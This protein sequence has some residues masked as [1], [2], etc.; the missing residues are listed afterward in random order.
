MTSEEKLIAFR[1]IYEAEL[2]NFPGNDSEQAGRWFRFISGVPEEKYEALMIAVSESW[3]SR[4]GKPRLREFRTVW[5]RMQFQTSPDRP[6]EAMCAAC[7]DHG[8]IVIPVHDVRQDGKHLRYVFGADD[9]GVLTEIACPCR[10][11]RGR[12]KQLVLGLSDNLCNEAW[13]FYRDLMIAAGHKQIEAPMSK[14]EYLRTQPEHRC[15]SPNGMKWRMVFDSRKELREALSSAETQ[16]KEPVPDPVV[17]EPTPEPWQ[18]RE[19]ELVG[20]QDTSFAF[21]KSIGADVEQVAPVLPGGYGDD[22]LPF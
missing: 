10:C 4:Q 7:Y 12:E 18:D 6:Q 19:F 8:V 9:G 3:G 16:V 1:A 21:G 20:V 5:T 15:T 11:S 17:P 22:D 14:A 2:G 13:G